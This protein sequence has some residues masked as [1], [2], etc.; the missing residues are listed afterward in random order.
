MFSLSLYLSA[1]SAYSLLTS[2]TR[3][4]FLFSIEAI[5]IHTLFA[6]F[7]SRC[8]VTSLKY[9]LSGS[10]EIATLYPG[11]SFSY[12]PTLSGR[13]SKTSRNLDLIHEYI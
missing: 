4:S 8:V 13:S 12:A 10:Y 11:I 3:V 7:V 9:S 2:N 6:I 1:G 5:D